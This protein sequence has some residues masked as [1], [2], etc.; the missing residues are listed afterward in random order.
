MFIF[1]LVVVNSINQGWKLVL[2]FLKFKCFEPANPKIELVM[3]T[4]R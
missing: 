1:G 3:P 2:L 4:K